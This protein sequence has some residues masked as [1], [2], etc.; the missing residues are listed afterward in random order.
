MNRRVAI[1]GIKGCFHQTAANIFF[2]NKIEAVE[3]LTFR[4]L[5]EAAKDNKQ[6]DA[7]VMAIENSI[8]GSILPNYNLLKQSDLKITGE[9]YLQIRQHLLVNEN[10]V[11]EDLKEVHSHPM[12][13]QQCLPFLAKHK[14]KLV[15]TE[16]TAASAKYIAQHNCKHIA[17]I[18]GETA[19][20]EYGLK[21]L[22]KDIQSEKNNYTR[23]LVLERNVNEELKESA[24]KA[25]IYFHT[26]HKKGSLAQILTEIASHDINL[27]K[28]QSF[29]VPGSNWEYSFHADL[30]FDA[31]D[32][33][34]AV[35]KA[36]TKMT[37][38]FKVYGIYKNG[39]K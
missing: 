5:I 6:T 32:Q 7:A 34:N 15:E 39:L 35:T 38:A 24:D 4:Q 1:Q 25:S 17:A 20:N 11:L 22:K 10:I 30:E 9:V 2:G 28:L 14:L 36:L 13:I 27:S 18:A 3:C 21:I 26:E 19:A 8:A 37:S 29:P 12:A 16:D 33:L 31:I 23:F